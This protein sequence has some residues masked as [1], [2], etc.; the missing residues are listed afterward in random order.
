MNLIFAISN[1]QLRCIKCRFK[2]SCPGSL[3]TFSMSGIELSGW[4]DCS[5]EILM[6]YEKPF[7]LKKKTKQ[8]HSTKASVQTSSFTSSALRRHLSALGI[9]RQREHEQK[10]GE[11]SRDNCCSDWLICC[12]T[13]RREVWEGGW[14]GQ[15]LVTYRESTCLVLIIK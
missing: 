9:F 12:C 6:S 13:C 11:R 5:Y 4:I 2:S 15:V 1:V 10:F 3:Y 8:K 14:G 7:S